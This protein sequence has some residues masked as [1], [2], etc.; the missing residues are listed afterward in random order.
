M[1]EKRYV[2]NKIKYLTLNCVVFSKM[3]S[4]GKKEQPETHCACLDLRDRPD[5]FGP[6]IKHGQNLSN[7]WN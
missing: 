1:V 6:F 5:L 3:L 4:Q 2:S 7:E